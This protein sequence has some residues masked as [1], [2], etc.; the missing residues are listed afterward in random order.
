MSVVMGEFD[1]DK[2]HKLL[3]T[4]YAHFNQE[5]VSSAEALMLLAYVVAVLNKERMCEDDVSIFANNMGEFVR[6]CTVLFNS[7][8]MK[9]DEE[10]GQLQ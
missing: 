4:V 6:I 3:A 9:S 5:K 2:A 7:I 8:K 1:I 10:Q